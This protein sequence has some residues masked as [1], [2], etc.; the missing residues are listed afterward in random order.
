MIIL[1]RDGDY[2]N[3][4]HL[5]RETLRIEKRFLD[6]SGRSFNINPGAVGTY[7]LC[8]ASH[9]ETGDRREISGYIAGCRL[10]FV[11]LI[12][13]SETYYERIMRWR[14][15]KMTLTGR[16]EA[17]N[18]FPEYAEANRIEKFEELVRTLP[19]NDVSVELMVDR[20]YPRT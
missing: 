1:E 9:K 14:D 2:A 3:L 19:K 5:K 17:E 8:L 15:G 6:P 10:N 11:N 7:G 18:K 16:A 4:H 13:G 20:Y 12:L